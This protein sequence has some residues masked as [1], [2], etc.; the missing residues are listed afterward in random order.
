MIIK[1]SA[2]KLPEIQP[3]L[4]LINFF[5]IAREILLQRPDQLYCN[6]STSNAFEEAA[7]LMIHKPKNMSESLGEDITVYHTKE[8]IGFKHLLQ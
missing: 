3:S 7:L 6:V 2:I 8:F 1:H 5:K 4:V